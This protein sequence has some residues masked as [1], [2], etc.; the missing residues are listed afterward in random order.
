MESTR[1]KRSG[2]GSWPH[3]LVQM[4]LGSFP[5]WGDGAELESLT[6]FW[7]SQHIGPSYL[8]LSV[9]PLAFRLD[10]RLER[11]FVTWVHP[12]TSTACVSCDFL[13]SSFCRHRLPSRP[14]LCVVCSLFLE[15][16]SSPPGYLPFHSQACARPLTPRCPPSL[17]HCWPTARRTLFSVSCFTSLRQRAPGS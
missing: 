1:L 11:L 15:G 9:E 8:A 10:A 6:F 2:L 5:S 14:G 7:H 13:P 4:C 3:G 12:P 17:L 16:P